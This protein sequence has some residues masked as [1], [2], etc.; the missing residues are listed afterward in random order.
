MAEGPW[1]A[2]ERRG[3]NCPVE[4]ATKRPAFLLSLRPCHPSPH[5]F[6]DDSEAGPASFNLEP[7][8]MLAAAFRTFRLHHSLFSQFKM[9]KSFYSMHV[10]DFSSRTEF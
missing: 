2:I 9:D 4:M 1:V 8:P 10:R 3:S 5:S 6:V 7:F